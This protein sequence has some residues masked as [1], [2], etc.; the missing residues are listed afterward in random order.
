MEFT[1]T[2]WEEQEELL[3]QKKKIDELEEK[4]QKK[5]EVISEI[6]EENMLFKKNFGGRG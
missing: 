6:A 5:D 2:L 1:D 4:L 3:R